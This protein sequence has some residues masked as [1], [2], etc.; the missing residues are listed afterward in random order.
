MLHPVPPEAAAEWGSADGSAI[1]PPAPAPPGG[2]PSATQVLH[3]LCR[4]F[5][6]MGQLLYQPPAMLT[7]WRFRDSSR[8]EH[9]SSRC[10]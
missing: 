2:N 3:S 6:H 9:S 10:Q 1:E 7:S 5:M 4:V 8:S